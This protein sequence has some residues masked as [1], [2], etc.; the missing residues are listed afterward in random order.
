MFG[1]GI[2]DDGIHLALGPFACMG[3]VD[4]T[5]LDTGSH[6]IAG[7][8]GGAYSHGHVVQQQAQATVANCQ[9]HVCVAGCR[10]G[11]DDFLN[12]VDG[13]I[14]TTDVQMEYADE[15][16][17]RSCGRCGHGRN[18]CQHQHECQE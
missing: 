9:L 17:V 2:T 6:F 11:V 1:R 3:K 8:C 14:L 13:E 4:V 15:V 12:L 10:Q 16:L 5:G 7:I 18:C